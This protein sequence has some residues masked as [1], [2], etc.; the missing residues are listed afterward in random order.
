VTT[1]AAGAANNITL[2][3]AGNNF[4]TVGIASGNNVAVTDATA[5]DLAFSTVSG[6]LSVVTN[7]AITQSGAVIVPGTT[8]WP[9]VPGTTSPSTM[10][11]I[12]STPWA[13]QAGTM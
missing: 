7:G 5:L 1:L 13:S 10:R 3:N 2:N 12:T 8:T 4:S 11:G 6:N 9:P